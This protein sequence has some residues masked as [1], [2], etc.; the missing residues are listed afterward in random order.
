M[1]E[2]PIAQGRGRLTAERTQEVYDSV[3]TL[4]VETGYEGLTMDA[5]AH[6]ASCSKATL[7]R[8]W[9]GK[10]TLVIDALEANHPHVTADEV[11]T[12][13]LRGDLHLWAQHVVNGPEKDAQLIHAVMHACTVS[14]DI[15][16][17]LRDRMISQESSDF[18]ILFTRAAER[19]EIDPDAPALRYLI[20]ALAGAIM[21]RFIVEEK[22]PD[23]EYLT[24]M[25]DSVVLPALGIH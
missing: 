7:Y 20:V 16:F 1:S 8:Q 14:E 6:A 23:E 19:G 24:G 12:G 15:R 3:L 22:R 25:I 21:L 17:T 4:L 2:T 9:G 5:I 11:D 18:A 10:E 13:S